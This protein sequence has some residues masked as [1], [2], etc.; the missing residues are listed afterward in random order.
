MLR[1]AIVFLVIALIAGALGLFR[2]EAVSATLAWWMFAIFL[3][4]FVVSLVFGG[5]RR[6]PV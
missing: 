6:P 1:L 3:I 5:L 4:L 2:T